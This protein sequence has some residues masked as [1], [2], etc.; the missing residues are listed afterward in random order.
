[1]PEWSNGLDWK[2]SNLLIGIHEFESHFI[3][4]L[5]GEVPELVIGPV[6]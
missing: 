2:S 1:M 5:Y 4:N 3:R 6:C